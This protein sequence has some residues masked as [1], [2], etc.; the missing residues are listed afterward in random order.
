MQHLSTA[1]HI[2]TVLMSGWSQAGGEL[3]E[4]TATSDRDQAANEAEWDTLTQL[5]E[6]DRRQQVPLASQCQLQGSGVGVVFV[7]SMCL[8]CRGARWAVP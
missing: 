8:C 4:L 2:S 1:H 6:A 7:V 3:A 5:I